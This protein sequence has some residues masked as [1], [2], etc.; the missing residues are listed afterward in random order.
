MAGQG[1]ELLLQPRGRAVGGLHVV[2]VEV[3]AGIDRGGAPGGDGGVKGSHQV[4]TLKRCAQHLGRYLGGDRLVGL[5]A[6]GGARGEAEDAPSLQ[7]DRGSAD[8]ADARRLL[9]L[10]ND[11]H[12]PGQVPASGLDPYG[13]PDAQVPALP[14][15][16]LLL[17]PHPLV[18]DLL[19]GGPEQS[20][21]VAAVVDIAVG[22]RVGE[23]LL[24]DQ[25][26]QPHLDT[27]H[28]Q[29]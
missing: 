19:Q 13:Q 2:E 29:L 5:S 27:V 4:N 10:V 17:L 21:I 8:P 1:E 3:V 12:V 22:G 18:A 20:F 15:G 11:G 23:L 26:G 9:D 28:A 24:W 14:P 16:L 7:L 25:V 6:A